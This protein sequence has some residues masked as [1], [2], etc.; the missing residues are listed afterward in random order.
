MVLG[1]DRNLWKLMDTGHVIREERGHARIYSVRNKMSMNAHYIL[2]KYRH[3]KSWTLMDMPPPLPHL[4][5]RITKIHP[6][7]KS[8]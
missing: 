6:S 2:E 4:A 8:N 1:V 7:F 3:G 5:V